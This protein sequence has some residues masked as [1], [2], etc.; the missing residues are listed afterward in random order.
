MSSGINL[1]DV[2]G[3]RIEHLTLMPVEQSPSLSHTIGFVF[4]A[5]G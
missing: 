4:N 3:Q 2:P 1:S 5:A